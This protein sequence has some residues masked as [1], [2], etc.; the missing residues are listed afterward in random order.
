[1]PRRSRAILDTGIFPA[2]PPISPVGGAARRTDWGWQ[3]FLQ[4][5]GEFRQFMDQMSRLYHQTYGGV[6][7][8]L[9]TWQRF[10]KQ[11]G[12]KELIDRLAAQ[13]H[14]MAGGTLYA[15]AITGGARRRRRRRA[16]GLYGGADINREI[17]G[18]RMF[19]EGHN[20]WLNF[21][22]A[23]KGEGYTL[24]QLSQMYH[25]QYGYGA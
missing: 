25:Q 9:G 4:S 8:P 22:H 18:E 11:H 23:H 16:A 10:L 19:L 5:N 6:P 14:G 13:Y 20:P 15:G 7:Q 24:D 12:F 2:L 21:L 17:A 3:R 1:M